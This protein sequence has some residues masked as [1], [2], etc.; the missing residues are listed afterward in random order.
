MYRSLTHLLWA[1]AHVAGLG[2]CVVGCAR[3][4]EAGRA[5][6]A[7]TSCERRCRLVVR[8]SEPAQLEQCQ[9][10][11]LAQVFAAGPACESRLVD[12]MDC[13]NTSAKSGVL[14]PR[15][16]AAPTTS[17]QRCNR[18]LERARECAQDCKHAG[19]VVSGDQSVPGSGVVRRVLYEVKYQGCA[20]C[21][22]DQGAPARAP[23][24]SARVCASECFGCRSGQSSVSLRACVDGRCAES[25]ELAELVVKL[26]AL[27]ACGAKGLGR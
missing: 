4:N 8:S 24:S 21:A 27:G 13:E 1:A 20:R 16:S 3:D 5:A 19:I 12:W 6:R 2:L 11:C 17:P 22:V 18:A 9:R 25:S 15:D 26:D 10:G 23:C 14:V 7:T